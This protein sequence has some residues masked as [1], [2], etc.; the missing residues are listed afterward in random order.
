MFGFIAFYAY[1]ALKDILYLFL[2]DVSKQ[3]VLKV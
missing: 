2:S 1:M 3:N